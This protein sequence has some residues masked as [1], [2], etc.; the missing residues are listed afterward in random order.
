[1]QEPEGQKVVILSEA[2]AVHHLLGPM[3]QQAE[4]QAA[5]ILLEGLAVVTEALAVL[6]V[7]AAAA[8]FLS[9]SPC[10]V[11]EDLA[12]A[13]QRIQSLTQEAAAEEVI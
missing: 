11:M 8:D 7:E 3:F 13:M 2:A 4:E 5:V 10:D 12:A 9:D 6:P 1:M